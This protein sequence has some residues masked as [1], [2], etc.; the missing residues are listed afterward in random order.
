MKRKRRN[1]L[2]LPSKKFNYA[3]FVA[4]EGQPSTAAVN[5]AAMY[6]Q[7]AA[8]SAALQA[9]I[10][11]CKRPQSSRRN[12]RKLCAPGR[13]WMHILIISQI[14]VAIG[15][16]AVVAASLDKQQEVTTT[17]GQPPTT[18]SVCLATTR[19]VNICSYAY[20]A[21][22]ASIAL[23]LIIS[24]MNICCPGRKHSFCLSMEALF[25]L[26]GA[27]WW[28]ASAITNMVL[29]NEANNA[30]LEGS[31]GRMVLWILCWANAGLFGLSFLTSAVG[32]CAAC[33]GMVDD[34]L[35]P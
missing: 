11:S 7:R 13:I 1:L 3:Q 24:L 33:C 16:I 4:N 27:A 5:T 8:T 19:S 20:W 35:D 23:S 6:S 18:V 34:D 25:S 21:S 9:E 28:T 12:S 17:E 30:Q 32:C 26:F 22:G 10:E 2:L 29:T 14:A 15:I 31:T